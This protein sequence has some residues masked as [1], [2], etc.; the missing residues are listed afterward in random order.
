MNVETRRKKYAVKD[1]KRRYFNNY[2]SK[3]LGNSGHV[4]VFFKPS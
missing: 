1:I 3:K 2:W 4:H